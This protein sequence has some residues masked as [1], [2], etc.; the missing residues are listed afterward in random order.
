MSFYRTVIDEHGSIA[1]VYKQFGKVIEVNKEE[2]EQ[3]LAECV[4]DVKGSV[5]EVKCGMDASTTHRKPA[6]NS[7]E[8]A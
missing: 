6:Q 5:S 1:K 2:A 7:G 3:M 4:A 8:Q